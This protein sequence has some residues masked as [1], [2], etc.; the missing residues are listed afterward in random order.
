[1]QVA[2][3]NTGVLL[4]MGDTAVDVFTDTGTIDN[5]DTA[6]DSIAAVTIG[7]IILLSLHVIMN[8]FLIFSSSADLNKSFTIFL[9][10]I[11]SKS[12]PGIFYQKK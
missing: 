8:T 11:V 5:T 10:I 6:F 3:R 2:G 12:S 4:P 7:I 1:M 9:T